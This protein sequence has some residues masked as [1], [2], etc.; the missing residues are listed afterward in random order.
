[1]PT[2]ESSQAGQSLSHGSSKEEWEAAHE[3]LRQNLEL[4]GRLQFRGIYGLGSGIYESRG[5][6]SCDTTVSKL[7]HTGEA[8]T[9]LTEICAVL[10]RSLESMPALVCAD[11]PT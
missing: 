9:R 1:M 5:C 10:L 3:A 11:R 8:L 4:W 6:P 7:I 2:S